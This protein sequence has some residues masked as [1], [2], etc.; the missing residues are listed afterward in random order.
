[1]LGNEYGKILLFTCFYVTLS[2]KV[3]NRITSYTV[4]QLHRGRLYRFRVRSKN[5]AGYGQSV[6]ELDT[7]V[8]LKALG[9][10]TQLSVIR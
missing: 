8:Q 9:I 6:A 10:Y 2:L 5:A 3:S 7:P 4:E 1:M